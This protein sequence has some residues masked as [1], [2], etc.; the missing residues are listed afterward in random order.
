MVL[1]R[2]IG[3]S[4]QNPPWLFDHNSIPKGTLLTTN[5]PP[6]VAVKMNIPISGISGALSRDM[7]ATHRAPGSSQRDTWA[8]N[9]LP[10][11]NYTRYLIR[12]R[13]FH[14]P[15]LQD[16]PPFR[17][18]GASKSDKQPKLLLWP[19][20][21]PNA[22]L[23]TQ[24]KQAQSPLVSMLSVELIL[25]IADQTTSPAYVVSLALTCK[26]LFLILS[27]HTFKR[28]DTHSKEVLL[29][30]LER[31]ISWVVY[32]PVAGRLLPFQSR[33]NGFEYPKAPSP[34]HE[35]SITGALN[36]YSMCPDKR[37]CISFLETRLVR[38]HRLFGPTHGIPLSCLSLAGAEFS[39]C[40]FMETQCRV[41]LETS[42]TAKWVGEDLLLSSTWTIQVMGV[43]RPGRFIP[44]E[45]SYHFLRRMNIMATCYHCILDGEANGHDGVLDPSFDEAGSRLFANSAYEGRG[46]CSV[47]DTDWDLSISWSKRSLVYKLITYHDLGCCSIPPDPKWVRLLKNDRFQAMR[48]SPRESRH[49]Y[50]RHR[51]I[52]SV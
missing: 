18:H 50:V 27:K 42:R 4:T 20:T 30:N 34:N 37:P 47:C 19:H 11:A 2:Q 8:P 51:W 41:F 49:G 38:N 10:F 29:T 3:E 1:V 33:E 31:D 52:N 24:N 45:S 9:A 40:L 12:A 46:A 39:S 26:I 43:Q 17:R 44:Y 21:L 7:P 14:T 25:S 35:F 28:L 22:M 13:L 36:I 48:S 23:G 32:C 5:S 6:M 16:I 15:V